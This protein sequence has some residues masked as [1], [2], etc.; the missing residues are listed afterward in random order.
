MLAT[1]ANPQEVVPKE[2]NQAPTPKPNQPPSTTPA[3][4]PATTSSA[5]S[6]K[7]PSFSSSAFRGRLNCRG[8]GVTTVGRTLR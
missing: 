2:Y 6:T 4:M 3:V 8:G 7:A 5:P 1:D